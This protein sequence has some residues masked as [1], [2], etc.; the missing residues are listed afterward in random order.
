MRAFVPSVFCARGTGSVSRI[1]AIGALLAMAAGASAGTPR[2]RAFVYPPITQ[3]DN[4]RNVAIPFAINQTG[5]IVGYAAPEPFHPQ[6]VPARAQGQTITELGAAND[7]FN[8]A[9]GLNDHDLVV[10]FSGFQPYRWDDDAAV[11]LPALPGFFSGVAWDA[12]NLDQICGNF[13]NDLAGFDVPCYWES[14]S[15]EPVTLQDLSGGSVGAAFAMNDAG[16]IVGAVPGPNFFFIA[17]RWENATAAPMTIGPLPGGRLSEARAINALGDVAG[18]TTYED[19]S[20]R[21]MLLVDE[22]DELIDIGVLA[23]TYS[24]AFGV[25]DDR[26]VVGTFNANGEPHAFLWQ[27]GT[28]HDLN[29]LVATANESFLYLASAADINNAGEI[30]AEAVL[31]PGPKGARRFVRLIPLTPGDVNCDGTVSVGDI[32]PFVLALTDPEGY[33]AQFPDCELLNADCSNDGV[34]SVGDINCFVGLVTGG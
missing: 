3:P 28:L 19:N 16:Q 30:A 11:M 7:S 5:V 4:G 23:G 6:S 25:N 14:P 8:Q 21:A 9:F 17:V 12:N 22:T 29:E 32:N 31:E 2:Y 27:D 15:T 1:I 10:G 34:V 18:R 24:E 13:I 26:A 20:S 33:A